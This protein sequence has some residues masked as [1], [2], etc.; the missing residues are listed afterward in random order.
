MIQINTKYTPFL[1]IS[2]LSLIWSSTWL[3]IKIGLQT[4]PPFLSAGWRFLLAFLCLG[5]FAIALKLKFPRDLR[6]HLFFIGFSII[7]FSASYAIVYW[8]E[9]YINSGLTSVLFAVMPFYVAM[10]SIKLLPSEQI[11][12]KKVLGITVGFSG[13]ILIFSDQLHFSHPLAIYAMSAVLISPAFTALGT[14][15]GKKARL[16]YHPVTLNAL[17]LLYTGISLMIL[18]A[19]FENTNPVTYTAMGIFSIIYLAVLGT[20]I[21]F[22]LYFWLL[23][24]TSAVLMSLITFITPPLALLWGWLILGEAITLRLVLGMLVIFSGIA[25]VRRS[26]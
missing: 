6:S 12:L 24:T 18:H 3:V 13:V 26:R 7:N 14:I 2:I 22:V 1:V 20:A 4:L 11:T 16:T 5:A 21:A 9:Q 17:P 8:S 10:F 19:L 25:I 15:I 23:K